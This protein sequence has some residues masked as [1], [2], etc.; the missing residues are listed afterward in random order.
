MAQRIAAGYTAYCSPEF[1][2]FCERFGIPWDLETRVMTIRFARDTALIVEHEYIIIE[3][4]KGPD[5]SR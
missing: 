1:R 4:K 2:A 5:A 3:D